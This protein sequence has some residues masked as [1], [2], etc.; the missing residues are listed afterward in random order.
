MAPRPSA[1]SSPTRRPAHL[2]MA[3]RP[4]ASSSPCASGGQRGSRFKQSAMNWLNNACMRHVPMDHQWSVMAV[5][6][7]TCLGLMKGWRPPRRGC[8]GRRTHRTTCSH[9]HPPYLPHHRC[10]PRS[11]LLLHQVR[12]SSSPSSLAAPA[13][14]LP[15]LAT[16]WHVAA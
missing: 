9:S 1:F 6:A 12:P 13:Q 5:N 3:W 15:S 16:H 11:Y 8:S 10:R 14:R 7:T 2:P 4:G